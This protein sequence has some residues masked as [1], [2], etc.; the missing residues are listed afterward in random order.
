MR[1]ILVHRTWLSV[2]TLCLCA[3]SNQ[4]SMAVTRP[5]AEDRDFLN[6]LFPSGPSS[7][8]NQPA[9]PQ[10]SQTPRVSI[11]E[12][13]QPKI[14][15]DPEN[16]STRLKLDP[17]HAEEKEKEQKRRQLI[18]RQNTQVVMAG[19]VRQQIEEGN[20]AMAEGRYKDAV[21][22]W[23]ICTELEKEDYRF[24]V[25]L[26][27]AAFAAGDYQTAEEAT[28]RAVALNPRSHVA[29][30]NYGVILFKRGKIEQA[31]DA[32]TRALELAPQ[33]AVIQINL[34][35]VFASLDQQNQ[36]VAFLRSALEESPTQVGKFILDPDLEPL[37]GHP[38]FEEMYAKLSD[39]QLI[40]ELQPTSTADIVEGFEGVVQDSSTLGAGGDDPDS[41]LSLQSIPL[42]PGLQLEDPAPKPD[43]ADQTGSD[44]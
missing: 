20:I 35:C 31:D 22:S 11:S 21:N 10:G 32:L 17:V 2:L 33:H 43:A 16:L 44:R 28:G 13:F 23:K 38:G 36:A 29:L 19:M 5:P 25:K 6:Q 15:F 34:A 30:C 1:M 4:R 39:A 24:F 40:P 41:G 9:F 14:S 3:L 42:R 27:E 18:Q 8:S 12:G 26:G 37:R 7:E